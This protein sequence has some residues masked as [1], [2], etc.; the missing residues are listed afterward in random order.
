V[1]KTKKNIRKK[2]KNFSIQEMHH[3]SFSK[4]GPIVII[5]IIIITTV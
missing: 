1:K 2:S 3:V 4:C 5:I